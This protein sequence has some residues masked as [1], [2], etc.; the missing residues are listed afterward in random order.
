MYNFKQFSVW[1][2]KY[3]YKSVHASNYHVAVYLQYLMHS[4]PSVS[5]INMAVFSIFWAQEIGGF[6][7]PC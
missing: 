4:N 3:G 2:N 1:C 6:S 5:K 7:D